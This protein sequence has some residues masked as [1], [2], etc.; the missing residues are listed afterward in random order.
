MNFTWC[1]QSC[2]STS[3]AFV[4]E[5]IYDQVLARVRHSIK[6]YKPGIPTDPRT[7]MG[8]IISQAQ[9]ERVL[10]YIEAGIEDGARLV[11]GGK[12]PDDPYLAKGFF[13][14]P[15][16]FA[17][18]SMDMRIGKEEIFGP[19]LSVFKWQDEA[20][21]LEQVNAVEYGLTCAIWTND[22][23][24][25]HRVAARGRGRLSSGSTMCP[26]ISSARRS[27]ATSSPASAARNASRNC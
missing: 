23:V 1:G 3:R 10:G 17:D 27:A 22:L 14:E 24:T 2:G 8:A 18:V 12:R 26:S 11:A 15:T 5:R 20:A 16:V 19:I 7:T 9:Y 6:R 21:M 4:H 25:A 13:I